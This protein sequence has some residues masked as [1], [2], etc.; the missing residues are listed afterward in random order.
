MHN[1][2]K[3]SIKKEPAKLMAIQ[4]A[5]S[6]ASE[7]C[8]VSDSFVTTK[9]EMSV[10]KNEFEIGKMLGSIGDTFYYHW[11]KH[12]NVLEF[13]SR[14]W[15]LKRDLQV[16]E[17]WVKQWSENTKKNSYVSLDDMAQICTLS[18]DQLAENLTEDK[19]LG[20]EQVYKEIRGTARFNRCMLGLYR[21]LTP[22]QKRTLWDGGGVSLRMVTPEQDQ[23]VRMVTDQTKDYGPK[24]PWPDDPNLMLFMRREHQQGKGT[25]Y[26]MDLIAK[27]NYKT[28]MTLFCPDVIT[29]ASP[30]DRE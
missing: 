9:G 29:K 30:G 10:G 25:A 12:G 7:M 11:E 21:V 26:H 27:E 13:R 18:D 1:K 14:D 22:K 4:E 16:P 15:F 17:D 28:F 8:I 5:L 3:L 20:D 24:M 23:W 2:V 6:E 19:V